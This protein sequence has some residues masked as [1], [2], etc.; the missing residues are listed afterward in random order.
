MK[1]SRA[2]SCGGCK[3]I[4]GYAFLEHHLELLLVQHPPELC[5]AVPV[6][7][8]LC[9]SRLNVFHIMFHF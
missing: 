6:L 5:I 4:D 2:K 1:L 8:V 9:H 7:W 3:N